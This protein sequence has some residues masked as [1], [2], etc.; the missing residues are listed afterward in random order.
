MAQ[1][2]TQPAPIGGRYALER[3]IARGGMAEVWLATDTFLHRDVAV[4]LLKPHL[5]NDEDAAERFRREAKACAGITHP[6]I[7]AV[8]DCLDYQGQQAVVMQYVKGKSLRDILDR[9]KRLGPK[10]TVHI[11]VSIAAALAEAHARGIIH[12]DV[13]PGNILVTPQGRVLLADFGI[14]KEANPSERDLTSDNIMMGTAKYLSPEQVRGKP[15]DGRA[16]LYSLG[17]VLYECLAG[18]VPF[19]GESDADTALARLQREPTDLGRLRPS[20]SPQLVKVIHKLIAQPATTGEYVVDDEGEL[21]LTTVLPRTA[22]S[23]PQRGLT[24]RDARR[25]GI[26]L[27]AVLASVGILAATVLSQLGGSDEVVAPQ[28]T[29]PVEVVAPTVVSVQS[30]V[31]FDPNGDDGVENEA[32]VPNLI[33]GN[34]ET[35]WSTTCYANQYFGSKEFVGLLVTLTAPATG[36]LKIGMRNA[37]WAIEVF[38]TNE[39]P[40][41]DIAAWGPRVA[42]KFNTKRAGAVFSLTEPAQYVL[43][44][45]REAGVSPAC[46]SSNPYQS[47]LAGITFQQS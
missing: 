14:A 34:P 42:K 25:N 22:S 9:Q 2:R 36:T 30:V 26:R 3:R 27:L 28:E 47:L 33:D 21:A 17:L 11:G 16:D 8:Y 46:S 45:L 19:L 6:N 31:S 15:L 44:A 12:R 32:L 4:K 41:A 7:V 1:Q 29:T 43:I 37:P 39:T 13:K 20:L 35:L 40:P 10:L 24:R 5:A 38:A 23:T 18:R